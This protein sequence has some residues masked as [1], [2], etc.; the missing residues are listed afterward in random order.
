MIET[1]W[2]ITVKA[3]TAIR[4]NACIMTAHLKENRQKLTIF[5]CNRN[6]L[7]TILWHEHSLRFCVSF[8]FYL[9]VC[10]KLWLIMSYCKIKTFLNYFRDDCDS[11]SICYIYPENTSINFYLIVLPYCFFYR[12]GTN[13]PTF[14]SIFYPCASRL[15]LI[16]SLNYFYEWMIKMAKNKP[17]FSF[18]FFVCLKGLCSRDFFGV[19]IY[20]VLLLN[21]C[22][23]LPTFSQCALSFKNAFFPVT[24]YFFR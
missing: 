11:V 1:V 12:L 18:F 15:P 2:L 20:F 13:R 7:K 17:F 21:P 10:F 3:K 19:Y 22:Q 6:K 9:W 16:L 8:C 5:L 4:T 24:I 14:C 23:S